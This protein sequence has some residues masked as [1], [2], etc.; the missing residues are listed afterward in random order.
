[1]HVWRSTDICPLL[2]C[3]SAVCNQTCLNGGTCSQPDTC[4]CV[5]GWNGTTCNEGLW[6]F[7][8]CTYICTHAQRAI[9]QGNTSCH[10][11]SFHST[12]ATHTFLLTSICHIIMA[13]PVMPSMQDTLTVS[14]LQAYNHTATH[15]Y[16]LYCLNAIVWASMAH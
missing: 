6:N 4:T 7:S 14:L 12:T 8:G 2:F 1:M 10:C 11:S 3:S 9:T 5:T 15:T 16:L 13:C